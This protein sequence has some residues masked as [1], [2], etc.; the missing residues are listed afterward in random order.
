MKTERLER[1]KEI[2]IE[3]NVT[4]QDMLVELLNKDG[5]NVTQATVSR[6]VKKL[7]LVKSFENGVNR[8]VLNKTTP[9]I[10][11]NVILSNG[12]VS[13]STAQNIVVIKSKPGFANTI[14][15]VLDQLELE[16]E[17]LVGTLAGDDTIFLATENNACALHIRNIIINKVR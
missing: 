12:I 6:D 16:S 10:N 3:E 1:I 2:I 5:Y 7:G 15:V 9:D 4:T 14:C 11:D 17:G 13:V 8:Y